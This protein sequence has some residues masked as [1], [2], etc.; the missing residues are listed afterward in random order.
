MRR[1]SLADIFARTTSAGAIS[2][3]R[4]GDRDRDRA[5]ASSIQCS[6]K[7][8]TSAPGIVPATRYQNKPLIL[9]HHLFAGALRIVKSAARRERAA[10]TRARNR[11]RRRTVSRGAARRQTREAGILA[12]AAA[13]RKGSSARELLTGRNSVR[14]CTTARTIA[15]HRGIRFRVLAWSTAD[16]RTAKLNARSIRWLVRVFRHREGV[17]P[18]RDNSP[19]VTPRLRYPCFFQKATADSLSVAVSRATSRTPLAAS[20]R[21]ISPSSC[22]PDV[23]PAKFR[24]HVNGDD[25]TALVAAAR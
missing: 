8:P 3:H 22:E 6:N 15:C 20:L 24:Q 21:S 4:A 5:D 16:Y 19:F 2:D 7:N 23:V 25:V 13:Q 11:R 9:H 18:V 1:S 10:S 17:A 14:P 12:S